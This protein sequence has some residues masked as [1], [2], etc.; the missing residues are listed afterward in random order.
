[1]G[2]ADRADAA[3]ADAMGKAADAMGRSAGTAE[4]GMTG[5]A[6]GIIGAAQM[7]KTPEIAGAGTMGKAAG[8]SEAGSMDVAV[9]DLL[10]RLNNDFYRSCAVSF[11]QTRQAPWEGW[12]RCLELLCGAVC[13]GKALSVLDIACGNGRFETFLA[14]EL[15]GVDVRA[16][17]VDS[18]DA[19]MTR[20]R[21]VAAF[22]RFDALSA[23]MDGAPWADALGAP[24][25]IPRVPFDVAV[26]FGFLHHIPSAALRTRALREMLSCVRPGGIVVVSL[27][28]FLE[29]ERLSRKAARSHP[30][31]LAE[32]AGRGAPADLAEQLEEGDR[33]LGWQDAPG[34]WRY[35]HSFSDAQADALAAS[36]SDIASECA[37]FRSDGK[38]RRL[39]IYL[40]FRKH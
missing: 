20:A 9:V 6:P 11:S 23:L 37:R 14:Q 30:E 12:S 10:R 1:M 7:K 4:A 15:P 38:S 21:A 36:V 18:C 8:V 31:A 29:D 16:L 3:N 26:C 24:A 33:F 28:C 40:A 35:C 32:L 25:D 39:N 2:A 22:S 27:W 13:D 17:A 34:L 19:L 5:K